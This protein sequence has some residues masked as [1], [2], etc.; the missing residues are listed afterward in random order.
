MLDL[1]ANAHSHSLTPKRRID[2][3]LEYGDSDD[4]NEMVHFNYLIG[5]RADQ[6]HRYSESLT[7]PERPFLGPDPPSSGFNLITSET[8]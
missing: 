7:L 8:Y 3:V 4:G 6:P 2:G 1:H 5:S